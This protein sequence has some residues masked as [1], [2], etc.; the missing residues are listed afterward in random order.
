MVYGSMLGIS[1]GMAASTCAGRSP[2]CDASATMPA[3]QGWAKSGRAAIVGYSG[4][5]SPPV[6]P[7]NTGVYGL[8]D[9]GS[10]SV[11]VAQ[12]IVLV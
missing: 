7:A 9:Q 4:I 1:S 5:S 11:G 2:C 12:E 6:G 8:A 3:I 10:G